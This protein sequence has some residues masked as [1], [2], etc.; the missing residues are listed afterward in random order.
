MD[1]VDEVGG[2][3]EAWSIIINSSHGDKYYLNG[4]Y[5]REEVEGS[6]SLRDLN[7][8]YNI[9][10]KLHRMNQNAKRV[11]RKRV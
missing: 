11:S 2:P 4:Q 8:V 10:L 5:Y 7:Q 1:L 6:I 9:R 3:K